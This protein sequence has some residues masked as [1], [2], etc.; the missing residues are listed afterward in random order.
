V[1][2]GGQ[3]HNVP[4]RWNADR[5]PAFA[6]PQNMNVPLIGFGHWGTQF[7]VSADGNR[8]YSLRENNDP[9]PHDIHVVTG[10]RA[11]LD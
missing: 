7:D 9:A 2:P 6:T 5:S 8:V 11:R 3:L 1:D 10:W 4:V